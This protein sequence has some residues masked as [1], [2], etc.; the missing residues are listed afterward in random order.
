MNSLQPHANKRRHCKSTRTVYHY[1]R[2]L[3]NILTTPHP[4]LLTEHVRAA[5]YPRNKPFGSIFQGVYTTSSSAT[6]SR[7]H[8]LSGC[9][10]PARPV[11]HAK[12]LVRIA[13]HLGADSHLVNSEGAQ[14]L[15]SATACM[16]P[17]TRTLIAKIFA[18]AFTSAVICTI[19]K[20]ILDYRA[21]RTNTSTTF[22]YSVGLH[23]TLHDSRSHQ[24][25]RGALS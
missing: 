5:V 1:Q 19:R 21:S 9:N 12:I 15:I 4:I 7:F 18:H 17:K 6:L 20:C 22:E 2:D 13:A 16:E 24:P 23:F 25:S 3:G 14:I 8:W 10:V 11:S